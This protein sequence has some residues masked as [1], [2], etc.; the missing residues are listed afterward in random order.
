MKLF[1]KTKL[2]LLIITS[3]S[4]MG[5]DSDTPLV[6]GGVALSDI[7]ETDQNVVE[8]E[9]FT[10]EDTLN[11]TAQDTNNFRVISNN[12][13]I[14]G[15]GFGFDEN[16]PQFTYEKT[17]AFTASITGQSDVGP[18]LQAAATQLFSTDNAANTEIRSLL[19]VTDSSLEAPDLTSEELDRVVELLNI[20]GADV[21]RESLDSD[22]LLINPSEVWNFTSTSTQAE[23]ATGIIGGT[24]SFSASSQPI[25]F[26]ITVLQDDEGNSFQ[27]YF[28]AV[29][30]EVQAFELFEQGTYTLELINEVG[31]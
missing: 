23:R 14:Q 25:I 24:Y 15:V 9:L 28:P 6:F 1:S 21:F 17:G 2:S 5:C 31:F 16:T 12:T 10:L 30:P 22:T 8:G 26:N 18:I 13:L 3:F 27:F 20:T 4:I 11:I 19:L 29:S 7:T